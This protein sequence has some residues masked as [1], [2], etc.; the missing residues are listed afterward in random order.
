LQGC[1]DSAHSARVGY[2][3]S[4]HDLC[5]WLNET[6]RVLDGRVTILSAEFRSQGIRLKIEGVF[7]DLASTFGSSRGDAPPL[8]RT[9][10][11]DRAG[12]TGRLPL[13]G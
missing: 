6:A 8:C 7:L 10:P 12:H 5:I 11:H 13:E 4:R 9:E 1:L 2:R 3:G